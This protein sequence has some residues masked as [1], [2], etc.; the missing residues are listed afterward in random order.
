MYAEDEHENLS[1][2]GMPGATSS[3]I[4]L[5]EDHPIPQ[6]SSDYLDDMDEEE[7]EGEKPFS[8]FDFLDRPRIL[9][10]PCDLTLEHLKQISYELGLI[11]LCWP[12]IMH[13]TFED[14][15]NFP[16][17]Y[18]KNSDKEK[19]LLLYTENFRQ[20]FCHRHPHRKPLFLACENEC[21]MQVGFKIVLIYMH[22]I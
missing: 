22:L 4:E 19:L 9:P 20:Q 7:G 5:N 1:G 15:I 11:K 18:L 2:I 21:G 13:P 8:Y 6:T 16:E 14:R 3:Q 12:E 10:E 17:S